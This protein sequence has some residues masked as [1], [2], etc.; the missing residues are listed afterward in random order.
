MTSEIHASVAAP[1]RHFRF[2]GSGKGYFVVWL[3]N[4]LLTLI[5]LGIYL[6]WA[7]IR[8]RRYFYE[9]TDLEGARFSY[10]ATGRSIFVGWLCLLA[11]YVIFLIN[12]VHQNTLLQLCM[13]GLFI[14]FFPWLITQGLRYQMLM[15][16]INGVR[17]NFYAS[18]LRA[19]W[20]MMG[21]PLLIIIATVVIFSL[22][23]SSAVSAGSYAA[24]FTLIAIGSLVLLLGIA[25]M[26]G[27]FAAQWFGMLVNNLQYS[28]LKF[29]GNF[30]MK[31]CIT[32]VVLSMLLF[33]PF[34]ALVMVMIVP[35]M[36]TMMQAAYMVQGDPEQMAMMMG[37]LYGKII[38]SYLIYI[39]GAVVCFTFAFVK[40]RAYL[41]SQLAL[42]GEI[43]FSS[44]VTVGRMLWLSI[45][46][47]AVCLVTLFLAWPWA[48]VRMT[49]YLLEN[50][51]VHGNLEALTLEDHGIQPAKDPAN[52]LARGLSFY[53][54]A[55]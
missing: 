7:L 9:N 8:A 29:S 21:C 27:V 14:L 25:V 5:T 45:S 13:M 51:H 19:W 33:I 34:I 2:Q 39:F 55:I 47:M 6:P 18:P 54:V 53:P 36:I 3:V 17:F 52:L 42:E 15:T 4:I 23:T 24:T 37:P 16:E 41:Y 20:V 1:A 22:F 32:I 12:I 44:T 26:Q 40:L 30:S 10:H 43:R 35:S 46:N 48:K 31:K 28:K 38:L 49:R 50:T 11:L